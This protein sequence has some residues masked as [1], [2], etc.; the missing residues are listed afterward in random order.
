MWACVDSLVAVGGPRWALCQAVKDT[1]PALSALIPPSFLHFFFST[2]FIFFWL[3]F[4]L[5][6]WKIFPPFFFL[7]WQTT[8]LQRKRT[9]KKEEEKREKRNTANSECGDAGR[10]ALQR[11]EVQRQRRWMER[12]REGRRQSEERWKRPSGNHD[13]M[14]SEVRPSCSHIGTTWTPRKAHTHAHTNTHTHTHTH[15]IS[16]CLTL[17]DHSCCEKQC[18]HCRS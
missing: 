13:V 1:N 6:A 17:T 5:F 14:I 2:S 18:G 15:T 4:R 11:Q 9:K 16:L 7:P 10:F 3:S 8:R 12:Q